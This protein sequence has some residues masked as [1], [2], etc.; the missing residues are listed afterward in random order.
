MDPQYHPKSLEPAVQQEWAET[1]AFV[2]PD[3]SDRPKYYDV[4]MLPYPSGKLHMGHVRNYSINDALCHFLRMKGYNVLQPM[5]WD[6]FGLPAENAAMANGVPPAKWTWDNIAYMKKQLQSL[7][8]AIDWTRELAT[9]SPDYY[10]WNQWFFLR[11]REKGIAYKKTGTVNWDPVDQ[12]V[13]ANEQVIDGKG[14]RTGAPVEKR[15][16]PMWYL[17]ITQYADELVDSLDAL[18]WPEQVKQMQRNWIGRSYGVEFTLPYAPE[19]AARMA[20]GKAGLKV[21][22][23]RADTIMGITFAAVAAEHALATEAAKGNAPLAAFIEECKKGGVMEAELATMEKKGMPTGLFVLHPFTKEKV[24]VWVGNYVLMG[25]GE[26]AVM[27]VPGHDERDFAFAKRYGL[28]IAQVI[29]VDGQAYS[30]D[31]W[32]PWYE[33]PGV[34]VNSGKYD[35]L[36]QAACIDAVA[37][38]LAA[39]GLGA[40]R[41]QFR[42]RDWGISRQRYWGTPIPIMHCPKCG[43][44]AVPDEE[45]PV[46]LP[47]DLVPDGSGSPLAKSRAFYE[48]KCPA[49]G[50]DA[51]RETD[52]MDTFVDSSWYFMRYACPGAKTMVDER[53]GY[54]MPMD[55]Y[56]GGIEHAILHLLYA[57]FWTKA[58]RDLGLVKFDEPFANLLT[59]GMVLNHIYS[60]RTDKGGIAYYAP[61]EIEAKTDAEGRITG[62]T[63]K[64]DGGPVDYGGIGTMSKSKRNGVDPQDLIDRYGAD[65]ARLYVMFASPPT[66]TILWSDTSVEGSF[67]FLRRLWKLVHEHLEAGGPVPGRAQGELP[68]PLRDLRY[69]LHR[70]IDK[71]ADD[72][73]R[74]LQFNTAIAAVMELLNAHADAKDGSPQGRAV[75]QE[76]LEAAVLLLSPVVPHIATALWAGLRPGTRLI[77]QRWPET[78]R[79]ALVQDTIELVLQVNGK[80]RGH[81]GA[82]ADA[83]REDI[84][85]LALASEAAAKFMEGRPAKKVVVVPGRLVNIVV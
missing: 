39:L 75:A 80:L 2:A 54:W 51:R 67:R 48:C 57:R 43:D 6:A 46:V 62:A 72:Y 9:C 8:F 25:Y 60:R 44:V 35:G 22:T 7:G 73:G 85:A 27:A 68:K 78:D 5:G 13:L 10:R 69:K 83:T 21:F 81:I 38:D 53:A 55:Q 42:L 56:I 64:A 30:T 40:K 76:V 65:T 45:L 66:D 82:A 63:L 41:V 16:I 23:T 34:N 70:T 14:W 24:E 33:A 49:C 61:E 12:T 52:T 37:A 18:G 1:K 3:A 29:D 11:L 26:G 47:E 17:R 15:E 74:R 50:A 28:A 77:D 58:M 4:G 19:T 84:E 20:D 79:A 71:V 36:G 32:Q 31:A 59:Q